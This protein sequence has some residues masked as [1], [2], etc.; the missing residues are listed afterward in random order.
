MQPE[1]LRRLYGSNVRA[2][3]K[4]LGLTQD[5]LAV[6]LGVTQAYIAAIEAGVSWPR[7]AIFAKLAEALQTSPSALLSADGI[8]SEIR[9]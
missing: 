3:R 8:F 4:E 5:E 1:E 6:S 9:S 2:R 7:I